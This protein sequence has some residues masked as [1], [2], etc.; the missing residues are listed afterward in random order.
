MSLILE[1]AMIARM[2]IPT[3]FYIN[4]NKLGKHNCRSL[5]A[6]TALATVVLGFVKVI[7]KF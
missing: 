5:S 6:E 1:I 2:G 7:Q 4:P 3:S